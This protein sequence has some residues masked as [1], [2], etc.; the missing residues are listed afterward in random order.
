MINPQVLS[1]LPVGCLAV[2]KTELPSLFTVS[3]VAHRTAAYS[4]STLHFFSCSLLCHRGGETFTFTEMNSGG[5]EQLEVF[6]LKYVILRR[7]KKDQKNLLS[8]QR[9]RYKSTL[10]LIVIADFSSST[11]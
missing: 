10:L 8:S 1:V 7:T 2:C 6:E 3:T 9:D 4:D 11:E 5:V